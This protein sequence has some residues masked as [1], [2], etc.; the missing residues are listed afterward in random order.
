MRRFIGHRV[1]VSTLDGGAVSGVLQRATRDG[2]ELRKAREV[3]R[4]VDL[5]GIVWIPAPQVAQA[6]AVSE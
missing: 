4:N 1:L 3:V 2:I 6:Q 5:D